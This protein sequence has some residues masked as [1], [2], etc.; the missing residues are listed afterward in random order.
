[1]SEQTTTTQ[2]VSATSVS[3]FASNAWSEQTQPEG[4]P[5]GE[6][7]RTGESTETQ[8]GNTESATSETQAQQTSPDYNVYL[9][10]KFGWDN[11]DVAKQEIEQLRTKA[12]PQE[13]A[14]EFSRNAYEYLISG[15]E[16]DLYSI[17]NQKKQVE[18]YISADVTDEKVAAELVKFNIHSENK[19]LSPDEV[20]FLFNKR[21]T[22]PKEPAQKADELDEDFE[23]RKQE[24]SYNVNSI[25]KELIIEAKLAKPKLEKLKADLV[26]P[27]IG[28]SVS[29]EQSQ[30]DLRKLE[31]NTLRFNQ[32]VDAE[33]KNFNG[34][35]TKYKDEEVEI[36]VSFSYDEAQKTALKEE[37]K[38][39]NV[40]AFINERW[41]TA[42]GN[43]KVETIMSDIALLKDKEAVFQKMVNEVGTNVAK[44]YRKVK[45]NISVAG[46]T[47]TNITETA[48]NVANPFKEQSWRA[49]P[50]AAN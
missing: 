23:A 25:K 47:N 1:M 9:K 10:E 36:P 34:F 14:N 2:E 3:P 21:F 20:E 42:D 6:S 32:K 29:P 38:T 27:K 17:L 49:S 41:F 50:V 8:S 13:F 16:D 30:E 43:P 22:L 24:W 28:G 4:T 46:G 15:K 39:F 44:H 7:T 31:E 45:A 37:V 12:K 19:D 48:T 26:L 35:E 18:K 5:A 40:D 11:E 33:F